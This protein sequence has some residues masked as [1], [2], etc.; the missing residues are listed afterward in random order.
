MKRT[1]KQL[2][3]LSLALIIGLSA[4]GSVGS[5]KDKSFNPPAIPFG[6]SPINEFDG[7]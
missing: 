5:I 3:A 4:F 7:I 6:A 1:Y 2:I